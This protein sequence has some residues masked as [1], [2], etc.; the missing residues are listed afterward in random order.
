MEWDKGFTSVYYVALVDPHTWMDKDRM[1]ILTEGGS[2]KKTCTDLRESASLTFYDYPYSKEMWMRIWMDAYQGNETSHIPL[3]TGLAVA[4]RRDIDGRQSTS[5]VEL[6]S[7]LK[8]A[9]DVLLPRGWYV[10][11]GANTGRTIIKLLKNTPAPVVVDDGIPKL[12]SHII[13]EDGESALSMTDKLLDAVGWRMK[14]EGDG[15]IHICDYT[16]KSSLRMDTMH[17][18]IIENELDVE[19]DYYECPNILRVISEEDSYVARDDDPESIFSTVSRGREIWAEES[20]VEENTGESL[21]HYA[22]R[23]LKEMQQVGYIVN[24]KRRFVPNIYTSDIVTLRYPE[25]KIDG[26][27]I[28][29]SQDMDLSFGCAVSE[30]VQKI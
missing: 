22:Q 26:D 3:F 13:A 25:Q 1:E 15:R 21:P 30:E 23:K 28:I 29:T 10:P 20:S 17:Y 11:K 18:D 6:Y 8:P 9:Q 19:Y 4:P 14:I 5:K 2:I 12:Y 7:V 27:F 24:Y 16:D